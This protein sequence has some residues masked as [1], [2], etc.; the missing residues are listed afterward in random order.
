MTPEERSHALELADEMLADIELSR[1][2]I[3]ALLLKGAR[4]ARLTNDDEFSEWIAKEL[5][6][7]YATDF[8]GKFWNLTGRGSNKDDGIYTGGARLSSFVTTLEEEMKN[9][10]LPSVSGDGAAIAIRETRSHIASVRNAVLKNK[11]VLTAV[12][13]VLHSFTSTHFYLLRFSSH[14]GELFDNA[15]SNIDAVLTDIPGEALRKIDAAYSSIRAGDPESVAG[16]MNSVRRLIDAVAD[17]V[18]PATNET[19][20]DGQG[21]TIKLGEM[22]RLNRIKAHIDDHTVS[23]NHGDRLKRAVGDI[24]ARVSSGVHSDVAVSEAT[25]LFLSTYV[26]L[27]EIVSLPK[28]ESE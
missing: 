24:Y 10:Q 13:N 11:A 28:Q 18:F 14:Q 21:K 15:K 8:N 1:L 17:A 19:R 2:P 26:L 5:G 27:G 9:M 20:N 4:L 23:K 16:A 12:K 6:G 22:N 25:Y 3:D 7:Y